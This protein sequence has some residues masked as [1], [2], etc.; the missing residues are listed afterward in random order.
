MVEMTFSRVT[1]RSPP[2]LSNQAMDNAAKR[3]PVPTK[4]A[5]RCGN[6]IKIRVGFEALALLARQTSFPGI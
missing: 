3:S 6:S 2:D 4:F 1:L 5:S